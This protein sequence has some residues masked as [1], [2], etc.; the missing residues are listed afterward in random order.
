M[1]SRKKEIEKIVKPSL[2]GGILI[3]LVCLG[4]FANLVFSI[5]IKE[6]NSLMIY[7]IFTFPSLS[8][9]GAYWFWHI[10]RIKNLDRDVEEIQNLLANHKD[11]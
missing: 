6:Y 9:L 1:D 10:I 3:T 8:F 5:A 7:A 2:L 4:P 11:D